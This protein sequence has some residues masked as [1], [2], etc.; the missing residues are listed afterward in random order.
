MNK[1]RETALASLT[2]RVG[3][4]SFYAELVRLTAPEDRKLVARVLNLDREFT[5]F[6]RRTGDAV[7]WL[8]DQQAMTDDP[9]DSRESAV[10]QRAA[11]KFR[12]TPE[13]IER[14][15]EGVQSAQARYL[16]TRGLAVKRFV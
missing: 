13:A 6:V 2:R 9:I 11:K 5:A 4:E 8:L 12:V 10:V 16:K 15:F 14:A 7:E 3:S 1:L